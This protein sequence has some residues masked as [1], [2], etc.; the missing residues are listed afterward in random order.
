MMQLPVY[1]LIIILSGTGKAV[2]HVP[3][4][5]VS[6]CQHARTVVL[7]GDSMVARAYCVKAYTAP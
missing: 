6:A 5:S 2:D 3:F 4:G 1:W 7:T